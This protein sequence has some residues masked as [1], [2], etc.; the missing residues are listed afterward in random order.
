MEKREAKSVIKDTDKVDVNAK[1]NCNKGK[2]N[3]E[4]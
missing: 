2:F 4:D 1:N 3:G